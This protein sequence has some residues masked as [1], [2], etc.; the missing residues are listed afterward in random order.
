MCFNVHSALL[1]HDDL[2]TSPA[3]D[4]D[5]GNDVGDREAHALTAPAALPRLS[6]PAEQVVCDG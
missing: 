3:R 6:D 4:R 1:L 2:D 5:L